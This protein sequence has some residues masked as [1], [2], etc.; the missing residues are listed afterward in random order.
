MKSVVLFSHGFG[1]RKD[2]RG[3]FTDIATALGDEY[4]PIMFDYG[5]FSEINNTLTVPPSG[6]QVEK[7]NQILAE[8]RKSYPNVPV[9]IVCHSR[10]S[11]V[12]ALAKPEGINKI[13]MLAPPFDSSSERTIKYF[14]NRA[15]SKIN[16]DGISRIAR[17]DGSTTIVPA[18]YWRELDKS[19]P[20]PLYNELVKQ[21]SLSIVIADQD[22]VVGEGNSSGLST[23]VKIYHVNSGHDFTEDARSEV[24][25]IVKKEISS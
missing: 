19:E 12:V 2:N 23:D 4:F 17:R 6:K 21:T 3:L 9:R 13:I 11:V 7:F 14:S 8:A 16:R 5:E 18:E 10:G 24:V 25:N 15:G 20:I 1:V 22:E